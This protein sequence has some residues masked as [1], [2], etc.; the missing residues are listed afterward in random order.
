LERRG[1]LGTDLDHGS[2][3]IRVCSE[4][5]ERIYA[6]VHR[7]GAVV[8]ARLLVGIVRQGGRNRVSLCA[9]GRE[10]GLSCTRPVHVLARM[11]RF[12]LI[13]REGDV[14]AVHL[15]SAPI[16]GSKPTGCPR[17]PGA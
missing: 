9:L 7:L 11:E 15:F 3:V 16:T 4:S 8:V 2:D 17:S 13:A 12:A 1:L 5:F 14:I 6:P 10:V